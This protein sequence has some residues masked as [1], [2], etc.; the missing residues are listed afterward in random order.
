MVNLSVCKASPVKI[1]ITKNLKRAE[2]NTLHGCGL[3]SKEMWVI[4]EGQKRSH[5]RVHM[6]SFLSKALIIL[7]RQNQ[8][9]ARHDQ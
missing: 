8:R 2:N 1:W 6:T 4:K 5:V 9:K 3:E 7:A